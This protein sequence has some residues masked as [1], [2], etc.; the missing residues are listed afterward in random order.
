M[1][2]FT[3]KCTITNRMTAAITQIERARGLLKT[4]P[5]SNYLVRDMGDKALIEKAHCRALEKEIEQSRTHAAHLLQAVL[6]EAFA[7]AT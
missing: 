2:T 5:F 3:P 7:P 6:K 4:A 1:T